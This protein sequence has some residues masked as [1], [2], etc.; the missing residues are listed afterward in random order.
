MLFLLACD[1]PLPE[2]VT[3][4]GTVY[5]A[6]NMTG[7]IVSDSDLET[8][9]LELASM[10]TATSDGDGNFEVDVGA[11]QDF[12]VVLTKDGHHPSSFSGLSG[13]VDFLAGVGVPWIVT[14]EFGASLAEDFSACTTAPASIGETTGIATGE[15][16]LYLSGVAP[17]ESP[18]ASEASLSITGADGLTV[19]VCV[20][21]DNGVSLESGTRV[22]ATGRFVAFGLPP[23]P[24]LVEVSYNSSGSV[25]TSQYR[26]YVPE[27]AQ[28]MPGV[29]LFYPIYIEGWGSSG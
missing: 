16:R 23:G 2:T 1:P 5:D 8:L 21:D 22:G 12:F 17:W 4:Y 9:S 18:A 26:G 29:A 3:M 28:N 11:G 15:I 10:G 14:E 20:L 6:P 25:S 24:I 13:Y 19:P 27:S 7:V